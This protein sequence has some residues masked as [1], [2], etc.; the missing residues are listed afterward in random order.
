MMKIGL[1][2]GAELPATACLKASSRLVGASAAVATVS[3]GVVSVGVAA[4][5]PAT[6]SLQAA[7]SAFV[8]PM[9]RCLS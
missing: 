9:S 5:Q 3:T 8:E 4:L 1:L 6:E 2:D 7:E